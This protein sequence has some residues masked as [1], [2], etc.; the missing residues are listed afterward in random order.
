MNKRKGF[1]I[2]E[3]LVTMAVFAV[4]AAAAVALFQFQAKSSAGS[5]VRKLGSEAVTLALMTIQRDIERAGLGLMQQLPL[6]MAVKDGA[7]G[8]P[9]QLFLSYSD[10]VNM[11]LARDKTYSFF[12]ASSS[13][14]MQKLWWS[15]SGSNSI[16]LQNVGAWIGTDGMAP[17][18][19]G[20][21][22]QVVAPAPG[23]PDAVEL[24][25]FN[26]TQ[27]AVVQ[28]PKNQCTV[29]LT[30][31]SAF[32]GNVAP[33]V[34]YRL[35]TSKTDQSA[36]PSDRQPQLGTLMRNGIPV[37]GAG[38]PLVGAREGEK[39]PVVKVTDF[40]VRCGFRNATAVCD[41]AKYYEDRT[42][43]CWTPDN[44]RQLGDTAGGWDVGTLRVV[45]VTIRYIVKDR[46]GGAKYPA[47]MTV[48]GFRLPDDDKNMTPPA[49]GP[50]ALG[51][52]QTITVSPRNIV[53]G[54][55]L[56]PPK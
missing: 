23:T 12:D 56:G 31:P 49:R 14:G 2:L 21:I 7:S 18:I 9:D 10:H 16:L 27:D 38:V 52:A 3:L 20:V 34:S 46:G 19:G 13:P 17:P 25:N 37:T 47:D 4:V 50:W 55:Y 1:T 54:H 8:A 51:G 35:I 29:T 24:S 45:E 48:A 22:R 44:G 28:R 40:Q 39:Q 32:S 15:L 42:T 30:L 43:A 53:L 11:V 26:V 33:A 41:F 6:S 36:Y 5:N